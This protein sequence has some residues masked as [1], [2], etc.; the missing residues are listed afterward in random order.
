M[1]PPIAERRPFAHVEH[2][3]ERPDPYHWLASEADPAVEAHLRAENAWADH[4][5]APLRGLIAELA[6]DLG[7]THH[8]RDGAPVITPTGT[9]RRSVEG[10]AGLPVYRRTGPGQPEVEVDL[11][12]LAGDYLQVVD[13][14]PSPDGRRLL[15]VLDLRGDERRTVRIRDLER[16]VWLGDALHDVS[17]AAWTDDEHVAWVWRDTSHRPR[18]VH[19]HTLGD[20]GDG[21]AD[22]V[23]FDEPNIERWVHCHRSKCGQWLIVG[24]ADRDGWAWYR[25]PTAEPG[26]LEAFL[27]YQ[28]G[29]RE[30][31]EA[32]GDVTWVLVQEAAGAAEAGRTWLARMPTAGTREAQEVVYVPPEGCLLEELEAFDT[33]V[34]LFVRERGRRRLAL[35]CAA[36]GSVRDVPLPEEVACLWFAPEREFHAAV[37]PNQHPAAGVLQITLTSLVRPLT[38][39]RITLASGACEAVHEVPTPGHRPEAWVSAATTCQAPDGTAIPVSL[40]HRRDVVPTADTPLLVFGYGAY[41]DKLDPVFMMVPRPFVDRGGVFAIAHVRGGGFLGPRWY[42]QGRQAHKTNSF[43]DFVAVVRG[44]HARGLSNPDRTA[45]RGSSGG[46]LLVGAAINRAPGLCRC[47]IATVPF[48]DVLSSMM[49]PSLP[50]TTFEYQEWGDV[51]EPGVYAAVAGWD[52]YENIEPRPYPDVFATAGRHDAAVLYWGIAKWVAR[53]RH[54]ATSGTFLLRTEMAGGHGGSS[55]REHALRASAERLAWMLDRLGMLGPA[56]AGRADQA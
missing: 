45:I 56:R 36:D 35:L 44:L 34:A 18:R 32:L 38:T 5:L 4:V 55:S 7:R 42:E 25:A 51:R 27:P 21:A 39:F 22:P 40:V 24:T 54:T 11:G 19:L 33:H 49:D 53:L 26:A 41:G 37:A 43:D 9:W 46:G 14:I 52:P 2:G 47:V 6:E 15:F 10:N 50:R 12:E 3:T 13:V 8:L 23:L 31:I 48:V 28:A 20:G 1:T 30:A 29:R 16:A 17:N